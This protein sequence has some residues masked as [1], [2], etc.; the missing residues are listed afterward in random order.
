MNKM[1]VIG[2][3]LMG[4]S[5]L[6]FAQSKPAYG[7]TEITFINKEGY[8]KD[9]SDKLKKVYAHC[10]ATFIVLGDR[11]QSITGVDKAADRFA[12]TKFES[13]EKAQACFNSKEYQDLRPLVDKY[14]KT[15]LYIV[16]GLEAK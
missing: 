6:S 10:G 2:L 13:Y 14:A 11:N 12:I 4:L 1:L 7:V 3:T 15:K 8:F 16:E 9:A 5:G